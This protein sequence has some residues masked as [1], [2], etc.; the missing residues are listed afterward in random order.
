MAVAVLSEGYR[1]KETG[2]RMNVGLIGTGAIAR[3]HAQAYRNIGYRV[4]ACTNATPDRGRKFAE[5]TGAE[6]VSTPEELC[7]RREIDFIDVCTFP[8]YRLQ[9][10]ELS[11]EYRKHVLV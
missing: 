9:A 1:E 11:A 10:V 7:R 6:F 4:T 5:E 3:K 8:G 2:L